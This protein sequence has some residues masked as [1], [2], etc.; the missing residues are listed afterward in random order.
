MSRDDNRD[1]HGGTV[2]LSAPWLLCTCRCDCD[3]TA[4]GKLCHPCAK[5][6]ASPFNDGRHG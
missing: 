2:P 5:A 4:S 3:N 1:R 6:K